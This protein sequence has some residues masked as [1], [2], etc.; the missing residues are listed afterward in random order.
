M[1]NPR[2]SK[3]QYWSNFL[4]FKW[5]SLYYYFRKLLYLQPIYPL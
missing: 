2:K 5:A 3:F 1:T 4:S